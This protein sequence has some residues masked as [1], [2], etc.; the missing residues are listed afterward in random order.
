MAV[1]LFITLLAIAAASYV[2]NATSSLRISKRQLFGVQLSHSCEASIQLELANLWQTF[3]KVQSFDDLDSDLK[4]ASLKKPQSVIGGG[5]PN[6]S[7]YSVGIVNY[8]APD[9]YSRLITVRAVSWIDSKYNWKLDPG[10]V[11]KSVTATYELALKRS[12]VFDYTYFINNYG[13]M[14]GFSPTSLYIN[15]DCRANGDFNFLHGSPTVNGSVMASPNGK[16]NPAPEGKVNGPPVKMSNQDYASASSGRSRWRTAYNPARDG[17]RGTDTYMAANHLVFDSVGGS[18]GGDLAGSLLQD[19]SGR[20][21]WDRGSTSVIP[22][23]SLVDSTPTEELSM[24][25]VNNLAYYRAMALRYKD[26]KPTFSDGT[27][28]PDYNKGSYLDVWDPTKNAYKHVTTTGGFVGSTTIIGTIDHPVK[29]HGPVSISV[30][31][32]I[33]GYVSGQGTIYAGRNVHIV[34]S[35]RYTNPPDFRGTDLASVDAKNEKAD[36]LGLVA[37]GSVIMGDTSQFTSQYPLQYMTPPFTRARTTEDGTVVPAYDA[38]LTDATAMKLYQSALGDTYIHSIAET[39]DQID[40]VMYTSNCAGGLIGGGSNGAQI[41]G[42]V[43]SR[44]EAMVVTSLP[45]SMNYDNR[46]LE[47]KASKR[48]LIDVQLPRGPALTRLTWQDSETKT[49]G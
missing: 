5:I 4:D 20:Y 43:I 45:L 37:A 13:W 29:I 9:P 36:M 8:E 46:I 39:V 48:P 7:R 30:D 49:S 22:T 26:P 34:G 6:V 40:A 38:T 35:I 27:S 1:L 10:E 28:N 24:P 25:D 12:G 41:N 21:S 2:T 19:V 42:C 32:V 31:C 17:E 33:K 47:R 44:D 11:Y 14:D 15:G 18:Y 16:L 23:P 3:K